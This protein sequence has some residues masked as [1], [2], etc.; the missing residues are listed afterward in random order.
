M[1]VVIAGGH[2]QVAL[3]LERLLSARGDRVRGLV[4][5]PAHAP[6]LRAAGAEPVLAD[7]EAEDDLTP[8]LEG[9]DAVVFAAGAG[10]GSGPARKRTV[11]LGAAVKLVEA[12]RRAGGLRYVMVSSIGAHDP[13][14]AG[15]AMRP[16]LEAKAEADAALAASDLPFTIVRPESLTDEPGTGRVAL[17]TRPGHR[18]P[19]PRDD[20]ASV[21]LTVLDDPETIGLTFEA[22]AGEQPVEAAVRALARATS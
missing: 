4:R 22:F 1:D 11:D 6:D 19:I 17:T 15:D 5:D 10:P 9:A 13:G 12:A 8:H 20:V 21:L 18:G 16:Y 3:R 14:G 7:L 2:G